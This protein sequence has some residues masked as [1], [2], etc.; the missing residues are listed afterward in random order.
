VVRQRTIV[1]KLH[2]EIQRN[3]DA[4]HSISCKLGFNMRWLMGAI[5][6]LGCTPLFALIFLCAYIQFAQKSVI[7]KFQPLNDFQEKLC[8]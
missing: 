8:F 5:V 2:R 7:S 3:D 1:G 4:L 6:R